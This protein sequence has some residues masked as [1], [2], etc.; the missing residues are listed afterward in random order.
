MMEVL[1]DRESVYLFAE[2][3]LEKQLLIDFAVLLHRSITPTKHELSHDASESH[4]QT[5]LF[6]CR[7]LLSR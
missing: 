4:D 7:N 3:D 6:I 2:G 1:I 5:C